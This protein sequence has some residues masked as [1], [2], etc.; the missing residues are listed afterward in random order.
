MCLCS[1][2]FLPTV[3][4]AGAAPDSERSGEAVF[5]QACFA[6]HGTGLNGAPVVGDAYDWQERLE[7]GGSVLLENTLQGM[8]NMPPRGA[9]TDCSDAEIAAAVQY[10]TNH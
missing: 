1:V 5:N 7:K 8:N 6:C 9:C 2:L 10:L 4:I 3:V